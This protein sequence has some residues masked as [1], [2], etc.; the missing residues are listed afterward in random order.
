MKQTWRSGIKHDCSAVMELT[1]GKNG[2]INGLGETV[3]L[4]ERY[5]YPLVKSSDVAKDNY[6]WNNRY[7]IVTQSKIGESTDIIKNTSPNLWNYLESHQDCF[8]KRKSSIYKNKPAYSIFGVG[9]YTFKPFKVAVSGLYKKLQFVVLIPIMDKPVIPDD[10]V[11]FI[12]FDFEDEANTIC[13]LLS[14]N[15]AKQFFHSYIFWDSKRPITVHLLNKLDLNKLAKDLNVN[16]KSCKH[17]SYPVKP[18]YSEGLL[19]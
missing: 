1:K 11:N 16:S 3:H 15:P 13:E 2:Y 12:G 6:Q 10:T 4:E 5:I 18:L 8:T 19:F 7:M 14:S 17:Y 9:N